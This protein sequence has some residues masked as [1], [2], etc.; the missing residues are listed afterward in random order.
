MRNVL[1][2][3]AGALIIASTIQLPTP[4]FAAEYA[5]EYS[6]SIGGFRVGRSQFSTTIADQSYNIEGTVKAA[7]V[8]RLFS[9]VT[10]SLKAQGTITTDKVIAHSFDVRYKEGKKTKRTTLSFS[11]GNVSAFSNQPKTRKRGQWIELQDQHLKQVLD[12]IAAILV[13]AKTLR[14]VCSKTPKVFDGAMRADF[15]MRYVRTI[16]FSTRGFKGDAVTCRAKFKPV[17]GYN[18]RKKDISWMREEGFI[19]ISFAPIGNTGVFAP[20][21]AKIKTR[22]GVATIRA[23]RFETLTK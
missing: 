4:V 20:V 14:G 23:K 18:K 16:P 9:S 21:V 12:P 7:G 15:P 8:A 22:L 10:G 3:T 1:S 13:P 2:I 5:S 17:A 6:V 11:G 19:D